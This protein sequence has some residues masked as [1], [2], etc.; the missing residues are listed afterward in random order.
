MGQEIFGAR[1]IHGLSEKENP[2]GQQLFQCTKTENPYILDDGYI[3]IA[4][5]RTAAEAH[6]EVLRCR[7]KLIS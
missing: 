4:Q 5:R 6:G 7:H 3:W 1:A 2:S